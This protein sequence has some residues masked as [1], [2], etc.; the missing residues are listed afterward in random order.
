[1][2]KLAAGYKSKMRNL[3]DGMKMVCMFGEY[4]KRVRKIFTILLVQTHSLVNLE[5]EVVFMELTFNLNGKDRFPLYNM[6][7][8]QNPF[9]NSVILVFFFTTRCIIW[10][11]RISLM[12]HSLIHWKR[13]F[14]RIHAKDPLDLQHL[15]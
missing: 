4:V 6:S 14:L 3:S 13:T 12:F 9:V 5:V 1:M 7:S 2:D 11:G 8:E 15:L 10:P